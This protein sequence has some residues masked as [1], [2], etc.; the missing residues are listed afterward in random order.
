[1]QGYLW[2]AVIETICGNGTVLPPLVIYKGVKR[3]MGWFQYLDEDSEAGNYLFATSPKVWTNRKLGM[4]WLKHFNQITKL[5]VTAISPY[6]LLIIDGHD[7]HITLEFVKYCDEANI[8]PYCLPPHSTHLLQPLDVGLFF[9]LQK[10]YGKAV[11][12]TTRFSFFTIWKGNFLP[13]LVEARQA[14]YTKENIAAGWRGAG[15][16]PFNARYILGKLPHGHIL[17]SS[18]PPPSTTI[19]TPKNS[20]DLLRHTR[21]AKLILKGDAP[22]DR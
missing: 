8:K 6:R 9:P 18:S 10:A 21:R 22:V 1:M 3:Y 13:L 14:T 11:D 4:E 12:R 19:A 20:S 17:E 15:L 16:I 5:Q 7:S 2:T